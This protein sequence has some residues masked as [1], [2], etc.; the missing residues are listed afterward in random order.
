MNAPD[1]Y[2]RVLERLADEKN[3]AGMQNLLRSVQGMLSDDERDALVVRFVDI[4]VSTLSD[5]KT[6]ELWAAKISDPTQRVRAFIRTP[7][8][9]S[10][11][12]RSP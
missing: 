2:G 6:A 1:I 4:A 10:L 3:V 7:S 9:C 12:L 8:L 5:L 11:R